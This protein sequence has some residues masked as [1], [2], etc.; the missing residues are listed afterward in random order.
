M[1]EENKELTELEA[2][3]VVAELIS[4]LCEISATLHI[5]VDKLDKKEARN[6]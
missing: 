3:A 5:L 6:D 4:I 2:Q 1:I